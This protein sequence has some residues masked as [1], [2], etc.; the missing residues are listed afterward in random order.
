MIQ[1]KVISKNVSHNISQGMVRAAESDLDHGWRSQSRR[2]AMILGDTV[3]CHSPF[4]Y[5]Q[6]LQI[7]SFCRL[8]MGR[9]SH[10]SLLQNLWTTLYK[11]LWEPRHHGGSG[12]IRYTIILCIVS[13]AAL[14]S[15]I[16]TGA[17]GVS[18]PL[19]RLWH[20]PLPISKY[21]TAV[22]VFLIYLF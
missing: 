2:M 10:F 7:L 8:F 6:S 5:T 1:S 4:C 19:R 9:Y 3:I 15:I 11:L 16:S 20:T 13:H 21:A 22:A 17:P 14:I 12:Q 18:A